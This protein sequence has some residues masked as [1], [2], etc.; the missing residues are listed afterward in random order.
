MIF[1]FL[2]FILYG[3]PF[4]FLFFEQ[5]F[6]F[7]KQTIATIFEKL[8]FKPIE[9]KELLWKTGQLLTL[10]LVVNFLLSFLFSFF[11]LNDLAKVE[12]TVA[13][14]KTTAPLVLIYFL[15]VRVLGEEIFF[16]SF[17]TPKLGWI[18]SGILFGLAHFGFGSITEVIGALILGGIL[19]Y[20]FQKNQNIYPNIIAHIAYNA[21][22]IGI[23]GWV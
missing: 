22:L 15:T 11:G 21:V 13:Q 4:L 9:K 17:L 18:F 8:G 20:T 6:K 12:Q 3:V 2:D 14:L 7:S 19:G 16:R 10:L 1:Y 23:L 5:S